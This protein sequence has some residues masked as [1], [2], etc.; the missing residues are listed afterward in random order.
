MNFYGCTFILYELSSPFLN[1]HWFFDKLDMTGS[2][3][4]LVNGIFLLITFFC[5]RLIWGTYQ[6]IR[7]YQDVWNSL[8]HTPAPA[9]IHYGVMNSTN[10]AV[11][12]AAAG[13]SGVPIHEGI[14]RFAGEEYVPIWLAFTYLGSN[15]VLNT[16]N[17]Y[18]FGKMIEALR[19]RFTP[20]KDKKKD[21]PIATKSV[22]SNGSVKIG[23]DQ[24]EVRR[25]KVV[26]VDADEEYEPA[27]LT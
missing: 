21:K 24:T 17:F 6:S 11:L 18:W 10:S 4:Q 1:F 15:I 8:F 3:P 25:R 13:K 12:E 5:C 20:Q 22:E 19:K 26:E 2:L 16:L 23:V 7:V 27:T 14:M 9:R